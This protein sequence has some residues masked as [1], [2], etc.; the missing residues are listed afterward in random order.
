[1]YRKGAKNRAE[2]TDRVSDGPESRS[3]SCYNLY[4]NLHVGIIL[5]LFKYLGDG[6]NATLNSR[7]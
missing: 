5:R 3:T 1:M 4:W 6:G 2:G 7:P